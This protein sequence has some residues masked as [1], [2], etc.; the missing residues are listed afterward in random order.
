[1]KVFKEIAKNFFSE[2]LDQAEL[3]EYS[4]AL[5]RYCASI[6]NTVSGDQVDNASRDYQEGRE[7]GAII[8]RNQI[9]KHFGAEE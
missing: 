4:K 9:L 6:C 2:N 8:C 7:M 5:V 1:M 3:E